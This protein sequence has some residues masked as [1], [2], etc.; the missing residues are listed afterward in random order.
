M[1]SLAKKPESYTAAEAKDQH[2]ISNID[3][4][5]VSGACL[6]SSTRQVDETRAFCAGEKLALL[7]SADGVPFELV[8]GGLNHEKC[9][10]LHGDQ[11][12]CSREFATYNLT[13]ITAG[14][15]VFQPHPGGGRILE[16]SGNVVDKDEHGAYRRDSARFFIG[17]VQAVPVY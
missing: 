17:D 14:K 1:E 6:D 11:T 10:Y 7:P 16:A 4:T 9:A 5:A 2:P 13:T 3:R 12:A 8:I 15:I